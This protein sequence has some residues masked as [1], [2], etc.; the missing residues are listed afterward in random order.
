M[1]DARRAGGADHG[2][3]S[4]SR[5]TAALAAASAALALLAGGSSSAS[6]ASA[7]NPDPALFARPAANP[8]FPLRPGLVTRLRGTDDGQRFREVVTVTRHH[9]TVAGVRTTV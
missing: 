2:E 7:G 3:M 6:H 1:G 8:W 5:S 9:R 4:R